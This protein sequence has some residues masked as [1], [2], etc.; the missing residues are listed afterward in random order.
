MKLSINTDPLLESLNIIQSISDL[1]PQETVERFRQLRHLINYRYC[2]DPKNKKRL[3]KSITMSS[4]YRMPS[5][6]DISPEFLSAAALV[7]RHFR[8]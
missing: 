5:M 4:L 3:T 7:R 2:D 6:V 1:I 8:E